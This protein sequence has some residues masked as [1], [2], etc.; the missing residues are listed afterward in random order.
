[1]RILLYNTICHGDVGV[2]LKISRPICTHKLLY[3][4]NFIIKLAHILIRVVGRRIKFDRVAENVIYCIQYCYTILSLWNYAQQYEYT[5]GWSFI[6]AIRYQRRSETVS[7]N[8]SN[9][10]TIIVDTGFGFTN[11]TSTRTMTI[12]IIIIIIFANRPRCPKTRVVFGVAR[13]V[14][15]DDIVAGYYY[16]NSCTVSVFPPSRG[17]R[18]RIIDRF[19]YNIIMTFAR[20]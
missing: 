14:S 10:I 3:R 19:S 8:N 2:D 7:D 12:I 20:Q 18:S 9:I 1:M 11:V 13:G 4:L 15:V 17:N 16:Y 6:N 5:E